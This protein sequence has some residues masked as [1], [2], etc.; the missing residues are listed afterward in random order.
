VAGTLGIS[1]M[2]L[3]MVISAVRNTVRLYRQELI[4]AGKPIPA[5][6]QLPLGLEKTSAALRH[7]S[8]T[9]N[10]LRVPS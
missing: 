9:A 4:P 3:I 6:K 10:A 7:E 1:G 2:L 5:Q 8:K